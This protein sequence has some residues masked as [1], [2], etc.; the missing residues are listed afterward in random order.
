[1]LSSL[2]PTN[3]HTVR[4]RPTLK[5]NTECF[6]NGLVRELKE[7]QRKLSRHSMTSKADGR[8]DKSEYQECMCKIGKIWKQGMFNKSES[9]KICVAGYHYDNSDFDLF[10]AEHNELLVVKICANEGRDDCQQLTPNVTKASFGTTMISATVVFIIAIVF[11]TV[12]V[13]VLVVVLRF[14]LFHLILYI[15]K[16]YMYDVGR[17]DFAVSASF[18]LECFDGSEVTTRKGNELVVENENCI[19]EEIKEVESRS[20]RW[21]F[22]YN[23]T[24]N[25]GGLNKVSHFS[26]RGCAPSRLPLKKLKSLLQKTRKVRV[27]VWKG[28]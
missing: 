9:H 21:K 19:V 8:N 5:N 3:A 11:R 7:K 12:T 13:N 10:N 2:N 24:C 27:F 28:I 22:I 4:S 23:R 6:R 16:R 17:Q 26:R 14:V 15:V 25:S 20:R 1:M 18:V